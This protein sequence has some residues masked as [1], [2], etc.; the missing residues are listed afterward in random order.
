MCVSVW[1]VKEMPVSTAVAY[2]SNRHIRQIAI[3]SIRLANTKYVRFFFVFTSP[4]GFLCLCIDTSSD[5]DAKSSLS[6]VHIGK[7]LRA[8]L[9]LCGKLLI[10]HFNFGTILRSRLN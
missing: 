6:P 2:N 4:F 1:I 7:L 8:S 9:S 5:E 3:L 10:A